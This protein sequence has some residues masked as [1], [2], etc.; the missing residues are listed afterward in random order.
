MN[1]MIMA[2]G[3]T[4]EV[5]TRIQICQGN[6]SRSLDLSDLGLAH[7]PEALQDIN[8]LEVLKLNENNLTELPD[9]IHKAAASIVTFGRDS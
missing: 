2:S 9:F 4:A 3:N 7:I 8:Y 6:Y 1:D 5:E